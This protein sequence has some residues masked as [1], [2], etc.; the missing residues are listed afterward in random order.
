MA[1]RLE[2]PGASHFTIT[3]PEARSFVKR[4]SALHLE[5]LKFESSH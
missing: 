4:V 5:L 3:A 1:K 2:W